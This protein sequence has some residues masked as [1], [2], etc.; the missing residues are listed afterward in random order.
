MR[1]VTWNVNSLRVRKKRVA[2]WLETHQPDVLCLQELKM[3]DSDVPLSMFE[4]LG[5]HVETFGQ[6]TYN[7]VAIA[8]LSPLEDVTRTFGDDEDDPQARFITGV[9]DDVRIISA[10]CPN[11]GTM[12]SDKWHYKLRWYERLNTWLDAHFDPDEPMALCGD[13]NIAPDDRDVNLASQWA[14]GVLC[15]PRIRAE[16]QR[17][18]DRGFVDTFRMHDDREGQYSWWDYRGLGFERDNG[19]RIDFVM[20]SP[21]LAETCTAAGIDRDER[22]EREGDKPSDHAPAWAEF[23]W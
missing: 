11:G 18:V 1:I 15:H 3:Q 7:G 14:D 16:F 22:Q 19:L 8:S 6:K 17:L 10:Y 2:A 21:E 23:D 12:D 20:A 4:E 5:Y 13:F 9:V